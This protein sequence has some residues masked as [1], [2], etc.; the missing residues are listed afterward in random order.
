MKDQELEKAVDMVNQPVHYNS[1]QYEVLDVIKDW[2]TEEE[3]RGYIKGNL[4]K[5]IA[6]ERWKNGDEDMFKAE[7]YLH[8]L[9]TDGE[10]GVKK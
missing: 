6:R 7:F 1:G 2:L 5:Y 4:I 9:N 8:Y 3:F 10:K